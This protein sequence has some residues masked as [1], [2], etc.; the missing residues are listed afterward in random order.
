MLCNLL[1]SFIIFINLTFL[2]DLKNV[3]KKNKKNTNQPPML[4]MRNIIA[5][6]CARAHRVCGR[7][8]VWL[9]VSV[10]VYGWACP[11]VWDA[12]AKKRHRL[13]NIAH[14]L[15]TQPIDIT[16]VNSHAS[17]QPH[18]HLHI[19]TPSPVKR[20]SRP[21]SQ[22]LGS[23]SLSLSFCAL[24]TTSFCC[25]SRALSSCPQATVLAPARS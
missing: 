13:K 10:C 25:E 21:Y 2:P 5:L 20:D 17:E 12:N 6:I 8:L 18:L 14:S 24:L 11:F 4:R 16:S 23:L 22:L 9:C 19:P 7:V 3:L 1:F 15:R